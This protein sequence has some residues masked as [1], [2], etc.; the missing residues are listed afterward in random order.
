MKIVI[1]I[2]LDL[3]ANINIFFILY[4]TFE[5]THR[6]VFSWLLNTPSHILTEMQYLLDYI[7]FVLPI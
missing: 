6:F 4:F 5:I 7:D 2:K 3:V 1:Y